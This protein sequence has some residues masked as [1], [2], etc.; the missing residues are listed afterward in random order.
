[1]PPDRKKAASQAAIAK[2]L[3]L[4]RS[5]VRDHQ[6][7]GVIPK[8]A[9]LQQAEDAYRTHIATN[10]RDDLAEARARQALAH[11]LKIERQNDKDRGRLVDKDE[12]DRAHEEQ[13]RRAVALLT[14]MSEEL[15]PR[16]AVETDVRLVIDILDAEIRKVCALLSGRK[17]PQ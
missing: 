12:Y 11:A 1:M 15:G 13:V 7:S 6:R 10:P 9:T 17:A 2:Q 16:L 14:S 8:G 5:T 4:H 3:R